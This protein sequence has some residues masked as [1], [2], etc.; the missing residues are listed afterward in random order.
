MT[1]QSV[2]QGL[3]FFSSAG[4]ASMPG[5]SA[6]LYELGG[7]PYCLPRRRRTLYTS[8]LSAP[9]AQRRGGVDALLYHLQY[10]PARATFPLYLCLHCRALRWRL[11]RARGHGV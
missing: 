4:S 11:L 8:T 9:L 10:L 1:M 5:D 6:S 2:S 3:S 7:T